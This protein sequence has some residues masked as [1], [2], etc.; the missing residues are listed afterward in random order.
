MVKKNKLYTI[1]KWNRPSFIPKWFKTG[2]S[3]S[4]DSYGN[5][6]QNGI[7][8]SGANTEVYAP[9]SQLTD[10]STT[11]PSYLNPWNSYTPVN[12]L[13]GTTQNNT[14]N[15]ST[16][17]GIVDNT[18]NTGSPLENMDFTQFNYNQINNP[19][20]SAIQ[21][22]SQYT[23]AAT[24]AIKSGAQGITS[25]LA[26]T[27]ARAAAK[28]AGQTVAQTAPDVLTS[29]APGSITVGANAASK[30]F[31]TWLGADK[32]SSLESIGIGVGSQLV[33]MGAKSLISDGLQT[34]TGENIA[35]IGNLAGGVVSAFNPIV[36]GI[37]TLAGNVIGGAVNAGWGHKVFGKGEAQNYRNQMSGFTVDSNSADNIE[38]AASYLANAPRVTYKDGWFTNKGKKEAAA[39]NEASQAVYDYALRSIGNAAQNNALRQQQNLLANY[40]AFGGPLN[41]SSS[42]ALLSH[43]KF[44]KGGSMKAQ[45]LDSFASDPLTA[46]MQYNASKRALA[47]QQA[48]QARQEEQENILLDLQRKYDALQTQNQGL[49][50]LYNT[51]AQSL[52][53]LQD[54][55]TKDSRD[56]SDPTAIIAS[57]DPTNYSDLTLDLKSIPGYSATGID[58]NGK[59]SIDFL[60]SSLTQ[61][62]IT[63]PIH[64]DALIANIMVESGGN[65]NAKNANSTARGLMQWT[66]A[67]YPSSWDIDSQLDYIADT[68]SQIGN[69]NWAN[70]KQRDAF[71]AS[72]DPYEAARLFRIG[73]ERPEPST[74]SLTDK[75]ID[76]MYKGKKKAFGGELGTNGSDWKNGLLEINQGDT[77][78]NNPHEGVQM[79]VDDN[80]TPNLV[81]EGETV[82]GDYV[83]SNRIEVPE[84][85]RKQLGVST[86]KNKHFT[87]ADA[88][89]KLAEESK[90]RPN[91]PISQAGLN[92]SMQKLMQAQEILRS[93]Q[94][95]DQNKYTN[96]TGENAAWGSVTP[97]AHGGRLGNHFDGLG[98]WFNSLDLSRFQKYDDYNKLAHNKKDAYAFY[99]SKDPR[100]GTDN[101]Y[102]YNKDK[103]QYD[104]GYL[105]FVNGLSDDEVNQ[106]TKAMIPYTGKQL[107]PAQ[108]RANATDINNGGGYGVAHEVA[109]QLYDERLAT[110]LKDTPSSSPFPA[111]VS[112]K[113][114]KSQ[115]SKPSTY[116][117]VEDQQALSNT[118]DSINP[119]DPKDTTKDNIPTYQTW[120]RYAPVI[121]SGIMSLTDA[122]GIT[123]KP[124]YTYA[125]KL[126][127]MATQAG[128]APRVS[129]D[130]IG[131]YMRYTPLDR[132]YYINKLNANA[133]ASRRAILNSG[134]TP[135]RMAGI[136]ASDNSY[137][138]KIGDLARQAEEYNLNQREK[139]ATFNRGTNMFNSEGKLKADMANAQYTQQA[140]SAQFSGLAQAAAM[141][142]AID[143]RI[144]AAKSANIT[145]LLQGLGNIGRENFALNQLNHDKGYDYWEDKHGRTKHK[146]AKGGKLKK[147]VFL[148]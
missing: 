106:L 121:G 82:F 86:N 100:I 18:L 133:A 4:I 103:K 12:W 146:S 26:G 7:N 14:D 29:S 57:T 83:F 56:P 94:Q 21:T 22:A 68:Y 107:T 120:M 126:E 80:N 66:Q 64:Q 79:G 51:Q 17:N 141:R 46:V 88:S 1:N 65:P 67:R 132:D 148:K 136:L 71:L 110:T 11:T 42:P 40:S 95:A 104:Q 72:K 33:G 76:K 3:I 19:L 135:S 6:H 43:R 119:N 55:Y 2:G 99:N 116:M 85:M 114:L 109:R 61:R 20:G 24:E 139:V 102:Y 28:R 70:K 8:Y 75:W 23:P 13:T 84:F 87:F 113:M 93:A 134:S 10:R 9:L 47:E 54:A 97:Y 122:L 125:N 98:N 140:K 90:E 38:Q 60:R 15:T 35:N 73:Y 58:Y 53:T 32:L 81:E 44:N 123:N 36:G 101:F 5:I 50:S 145:N 52:K 69:G 78:E 127:A 91:D 89:K 77:H 41:F 39:E 131:D 115:N 105:D 96:A 143:Q 128:Y 147:P 108:W 63:N 74:Y 48:E 118:K 138:G 16:N 117:S 45:F 30:G 25:E 130:P 142:E 112:E 31:S 34:S 59:A 49:Q 124:D 144:G 111:F 129:F 27:T 62:G 137:I 92:A 37:V